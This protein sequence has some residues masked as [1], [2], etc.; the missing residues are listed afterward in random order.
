MDYIMEEQRAAAEIEDL[1]TFLKWDDRF[2][3]AFT[4]ANGRGFAWRVIEAEKAQMD[5][6]RYLSYSGH[7]PMSSVIDQ[8]F[9]ILDAV[10]KGDPDDAVKS[11][12]QHLKEIIEVLPNIVKDHADLFEGSYENE[13][14][15]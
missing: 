10:K 8:H 12:H 9:Q 5:R 1:G 4:E 15:N 13:I 14:G 11:V 6:V 3:R 7:S 2:H